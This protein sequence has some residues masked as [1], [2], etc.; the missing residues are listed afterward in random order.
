MP[1]PRRISGPKALIILLGMLVVA[2]VVVVIATKR[3]PKYTP[4][5]DDLG[6]VPSFAFTDE[7][8]HRFPTEALAGRVTIVNFIF[9]RC[10]NICPA[11]TARMLDLQQRTEDLDQAV[12]LVS[13]TVDPGHDTPE[14]LARYARENHAD[15]RRWRFVTGEMSKLRPVI[16]GAFI[17]GI[18]D[19][20]EKTPSGAPAIFHGEKFFLVDQNLHIRQFYDTDPPGLARLARDARYLAKHPPAAAATASAVTSPPR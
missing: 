7:T 12:W 1:L 9:T 5:L 15:P 3:H 8:G 17:S 18:D 14:V 19:T 13:F 2:G 16:E 4:K 6:P 20:G 11:S 10:D